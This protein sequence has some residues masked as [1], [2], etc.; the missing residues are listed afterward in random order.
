[1]TCMPYFPVLFSSPAAA[2]VP[3]RLPFVGLV[4]AL[5]L[6]A[7][8]PLAAQQRLSI[9]TPAPNSPFWGGVPSG[10]PSQQPLTL[11][12]AD[13]LRRALAYNLGVLIAEEVVDRAD[14]ARRVALS[15][16]LPRLDGGVTET[17]QKTNLEAFGF[18]LGPTFPRVVGPF[19]VFDARVSL[20]QAIFDARAT[21]ELHAESHRLTAAQLSRRSA[22]DLIVLV[23]ANVYFQTVSTGARAESTRAQLETARALRQQAQ[24]LRAAGVTA[25]IDVIRSEAGVDAAQYAATEARNDFEKSKLQLARLIGL[26]I[27]QTFTLVDQVPSLPV[28]TTG[29][30]EVLARAYTDRP[31]FLAAQARVRAAEAALSAARAERLPSAALV[32][33]YGVIGLTVGSA[34]ST[35]AVTGAVTVPLFDGGRASGR[36]RQAQSDLAQRQAELEDLRA[37]IYY[38]T[39]A[40]FLD[41]SAAEEQLQAA[42]RGRELANLALT[43]ARDRFAAGVTNTVEVVQAQQAVAAASERFIAAQYDVTVATALVLS[44][45]GSLEQ[46]IAQF[47]GSPLP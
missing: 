1:M 6:A 3:S 37:S 27:R 19:N 30:E 25:G 46:A 4:T 23:S 10:P 42:T 8:A 22:R 13:A 9:P 15:E 44:S 7:G 18:P 34:L 17:R 14:G 45:P 39:R 31:D 36:I 35:F 2:N 16:L 33:D 32:G 11:S 20:R 47:L 12:L 5:A 41:L 26:P 29:F 38:N 43:Q 21:N 24:E 28:P 40:A